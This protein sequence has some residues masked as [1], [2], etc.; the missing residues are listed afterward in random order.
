MGEFSIKSPYLLYPTI[1]LILLFSSLYHQDYNLFSFP[2]FLPT[3]IDTND[4]ND[5]A[6]HEEPSHVF[7]QITDFYDNTTDLK[8]IN[9]ERKANVGMMEEGLARARAAIREAGRTKTY[10]SYKEERFVPRGSVYLNPYAFHQSHI[11]MEKRFRV[12]VYKEGEPPLF[13]EAP[14]KSI[15]SSGGQ[16]MAEMKM[17]SPFLA[18]RPEDALAFYIPISITG[19]I[20]HLY[21]HRAPDY[22]RGR[23]FRVFED[24]VRVVSRKY[25]FWKRSNGADHFMVSCHDWAND[26]ARAH[27]DRFKYFI[28]VVCNANSSETF[29]PIRDVSLPEINIANSNGLGPPQGQGHPPSNR[30]IFAFFAGGPHG[31]VRESLFKHWKDKDDEMQV[32][33]YLPKNSNYSDLMSRSKFC[34]CPSGYEVASPRVVESIF[35][36]CVPVIIS[37]GYV[38][39]FS[40]V[41]DWEKFTVQIPVEKIPEIKAILKGIS[42]EEYLVK[43][44]RVLQ[45]QKHFVIN[46]PAKPYDMWHMILH[47]IWLRRLNVRLPY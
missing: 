29:R 18:R 1:F 40:D 28:R 30:T 7:Q 22:D 46:R 35:M 4:T 9:F 12:W 2:N 39:P 23:I 20:Q 25:P 10:S 5:E 33:D 15:Y 3:S 14:L 38:L 11:E 8:T 24:Y 27:P 6:F 45:V 43:R 47:S 17:D 42:W 21:N 32:H 13:H 16:F 44:R 26:V 19:I 34:L 37:D 36:G 31:H 41:L